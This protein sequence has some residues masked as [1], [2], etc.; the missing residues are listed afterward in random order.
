MKQDQG[1]WNARRVYNEYNVGSL[2][3]PRVSMPDPRPCVKIYELYQLFEIFSFVHQITISSL[4]VFKDNDFL[5]LLVMLSTSHLA[6]CAN[7]SV[8][9]KFINHEISLILP[10][11]ELFDLGR[12]HCENLDLSLRGLNQVLLRTFLKKNIFIQFIACISETPTS[13]FNSFLFSLF[14]CFEFL[15]ASNLKCMSEESLKNLSPLNDECF[16]LVLQI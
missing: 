11:T 8:S 4:Q 5:I 2:V 15:F 13:S 9:N 6:I 14:L 12:K 7:V 16:V 10:A 3:K 1:K